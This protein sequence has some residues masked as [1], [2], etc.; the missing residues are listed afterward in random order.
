MDHDNVMIDLET[1]GKRAGCGII[2]IGAVMFDPITGKTGEEFYRVIGN[3]S[4]G[5]FGLHHDSDT[6]KWWDKQSLSARDAFEASLRNDEN[7]CIS[8]NLAL[9]DFNR[10]L[11]PYPDTL[12]WGNGADFDKPIIEAAYAAC[13]M[14]P[15]WRP[16]N[17]RCHRTLKNLLPYVA[18]PKPSVPGNIAHHALDDA[19]RQAEH[20]IALL[21][22]HARLLVL[23]EKM[24]ELAE[25]TEAQGGKANLTMSV[26]RR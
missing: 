3:E 9:E 23:S 6:I 7:Q 21:Q 14:S 26:E 4:N 2:S 25:Q 12:V 24:I 11:A 10:F 13:G 16:F 22:E 20:A 15:A 1:F 19:R 8:L 5:R 17:G 18:V